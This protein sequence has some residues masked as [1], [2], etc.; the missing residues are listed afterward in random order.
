MKRKNRA[1]N[2]QRLKNNF[3]FL[4]SMIK[5]ET[6]TAETNRLRRDQEGGLRSRLLAGVGQGSRRVFPG[7]AKKN[8]N[9]SSA[10]R[11]REVV[12]A[13]TEE[14]DGAG[15]GQRRVVGTLRWGQDGARS[16]AKHVQNTCYNEMD[17]I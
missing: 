9:P 17:S 12:R 2:S 8:E 11:E 14:V 5:T 1:E 3:F 16:S 4:N 6:E 15:Q 10:S 13:Q 7:P